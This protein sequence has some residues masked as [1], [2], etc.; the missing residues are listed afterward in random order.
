MTPTTPASSGGSV[1]SWEISPAIPAGMA[2]SASTG[3]ISGTPTGLQTTAVPYTIWANNSGGWTSTEMN[4][5][6]N[7]QVASITYPSTV[8][9]SNDRAM[10]TVTPTNSGG[11]VSTWEIHPSLPT[12]L[13]FGSSNG[14]IWGTPTG[15]LENVTYTVYANNSGGSPST[16]F[17]LGLN[18]TL[19]PSAEG[20]FITRN[21]SIASDIM[22][23]WDYDPLEAQ[24]LSLVTGE[25]N[26]CALDS[27]QNV[28]C[29]GRN[30]NGQIGNGQ[31]G[32]AACGTSGHKCKD[33]PTAT[34]DLGSDVISLAF[35]HQHACGL[36][37]TGAVKCWGRNNAGQL[38][39]SGG[40]KDTPQTINLG[41]GRTATSIYAGGHYTCAILD[42][43]SVKCWGQNDQGQLGIGSTSNTNTPTTINTL[44][45]GRTA[46]SLATAFD[47]VCA[48]LDDGSVKCWGS[49]FDGQ[50]GNGGTNADLSSPPSSAIN[51]GTSRTAKAIT[52][53]EFHF[54]AILD[55]DSIKC[56]GQGTDGKLG[57][58][59][60]GDRSTPTSTSGSF[61]SGRYAVA[62]DAG[63]DHTCVLLDNG[64]MTCWGS[65]ADGQLGNGASSS[66]TVSS[67]SSNI[68]SL[69]TG[70]T[71]ISISAG[72]THTCA[73]L[74]NG[75]TQVLGESSRRSSWRQ[76]EF[77][78]PVRPHKSFFSLQQQPRW[79]YLSQHGCHAFFRCYWRYL[80]DLAFPPNR[81]Q[82]DRRHVHHHRHTDRYSHQRYLHR[83]GQ[84]FWHIVQRSNL[85]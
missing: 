26:T 20:A 11:A 71:A 6:I 44:G 30:G 51:L 18:W 5:T 10:T 33:I 55:D 34:N 59:S 81:P 75:S 45:S 63:Y 80:R 21:S 28:F 22:W 57:T 60:T 13:N 42:D 85:A 83:L 46:V 16:T 41:S 65:D 14:S 70:R 53:G 15:L 78:Q 35:G 76:R 74:D 50:L 52:G 19:T 58:G 23:E 67:L 2:F 37:D 24:N 73:Q 12:G 54:C 69:G 7:D 3:A 47:S 43:A 29:W 62:I 40:D 4:I 31:T 9:I 84:R 8:E 38:G 32:T 61:A 72:G 36:L 66:S 77:Q 39:T 1:T 56:W 79:E 64:D 49:D 17:I 25:W 68:I 82:F 27:N 48:L